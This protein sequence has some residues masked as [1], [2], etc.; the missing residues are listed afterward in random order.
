MNRI[1]L[2]SDTLG[3]SALMERITGTHVKDCFKDEDTIFF[4]VGLGELGKAV[5]KGGVTVKRVS[6]ELGKKIR[7]IEYRENAVEFMR[8]IIYPLT[9]E[10]IQDTGETLILKDKSKKTKSLLIGRGGKNLNLINRAVKRFF[11]KE[12]K[13]E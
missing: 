13:I 2:D 3:L 8:N 4:V 7:V 9:V 10:E 6:E 1:K 12:I 11:N 5:G